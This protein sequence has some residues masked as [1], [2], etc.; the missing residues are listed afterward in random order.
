MPP[1]KA[2]PEGRIGLDSCAKMVRFANPTY[3]GDGRIHKRKERKKWIW[4]LLT[5]CPIAGRRGGSRRLSPRFGLG[6]RRRVVERIDVEGSRRARR[7]P[8]PAW[9]RR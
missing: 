5:F 1:C 9:D 4:K 7:C 3:V 8:R 2:S 6:C